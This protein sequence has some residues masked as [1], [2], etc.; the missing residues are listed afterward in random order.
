MIRLKLHLGNQDLTSALWNAGLTALGCFGSV[1][2][3]FRD[4]Q[5]GWALYLLEEL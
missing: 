1:V 3:I 5:C 4:Y 2:G